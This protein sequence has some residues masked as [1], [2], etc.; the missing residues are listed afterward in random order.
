MNQARRKAIAR[1]IKLIAGI[2]LL[3]SVQLATAAAPALIRI[4]VA[5]PAYGNPPTF[6]ASTLAVA[7]ATGAIEQ[8]F[9]AD[10]IKV[11]WY[12]FKGAGPAVNEALSNH[13]L[14]FAY[15]GDLP[16]IIGKAAGLKTR[17][18][19]A[20]GVRSNIYL[21]VPPDSPVRSVK[22]LRGKRVAMFKGTNAQ[23][24]IDRLLAANG[25]N[26]RDLKIVNLDTAT[27]QAALTTRDIDATFSGFDLLKLRDKGAARIVF[28]SKG[29]SPVF[30]R[31]SHVLVTDDFA[32]RYPDITR[33]LVKA[34]V[35][36]ARWS[37]DESNR[38]EVFRIWARAGTAKLEH[39][40]ED[41]QGQALHDR[42]SP[43]FDPF[44]TGRYK[45]AVEHAYQYRLIRSKFDVDQWIDR[46]FLN[47]SL[48]ELKLDSYWPAHQADGIH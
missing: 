30:T 41:Y 39:W 44:L 48:K 20:T 40:R 38:D 23:L 34:V 47:A 42:L 31:Q 45:D 46:S 35:K 18:I 24:P 28:T 13:Q 16:S 8:E 3:G 10:N 43:L 15:Q 32:T 5:S 37:S 12:F 36:V 25:M 4:G 7:H 26:E 22:D 17:L 21:A 27:A 2:A 14:D 29:N 33:R 1:S 9:K 11:E 6:S 19:L